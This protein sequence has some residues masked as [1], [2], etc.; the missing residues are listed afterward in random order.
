MKAALLESEGHL[1]I[2]EVK[3]PAI[4]GPDQVLIQVKTVGV[5]G[6][7]VHAFEG[8]HPYR[9]A[10]V[11]L[12]HEMAGVIAAI[13]ETVSEF[14]PGDRV[15]VDPQWVCRVCVHC[16]AGDINLC[17]SKKVLG[18]PGWTGAFGE[19]VVV[20]GEAVFHLPDMLSFA[21][22][23]LI[24]PL[25]IGV[26]VARRA[27]LKAGESVAILGTGSIGGMAS[28]VCRA[29]GAD[30]IIVADVRQHCLD[31]A[32][33][34]MGATHDFL[35]PDDRFVDKVN[36]AT[37]GQGV[38]VALITAD[39]VSL[40]NQ[41]IET[42]KR[43]GCIVLV[44]LLT[45]APLKFMAYSV[46]SKELHIIGSSMANEDDVREAIDLATSGRVDVEGILTHVFPIEEAQKGLELAQ[47][48]ED[49]AIKVV[50]SF[51]ESD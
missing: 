12:G 26:H 23:S 11:V 32:R 49:G 24:E 1:V 46:I 50:L 6:S 45:E 9:K 41:A 21:Q 10:P 8:T 7:E 4:Q 47:T 43:R 27:G 51:E 3:T 36:A 34:R 44:A 35:L 20:P 33:E 31:A 2:T 5:C 13:G 40:V 29:L 48:K 30:P 15:V 25:T 18:I 42:T 19:Y 28:G 17:P 14:E 16:R 38:D 37:N 39:D 22:G